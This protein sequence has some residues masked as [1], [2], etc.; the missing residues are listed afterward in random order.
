M[1]HILLATD[2]EDTSSN[3]AAFA[4]AIADN[5]KAKLT[6]YHAFGKP[7]LQMGD[8]SDMMR[9]DKVEA[10]MRSLISDVRS[11]GITDVVVNYAADIDYPGDG[12]LNQ[13]EEGDFDLL[14]IGLREPQEGASQFSSLAFKLLR[15]ADTAVL[16][17]PPMATFHGIQEIVFATDLDHADE[18]VLEQLQSWRQNMGADLFVVNV[19]DDEQGADEARKVLGKW[20][21]RYAS[22]ARMH[23]ELMEGDFEN[24]IGAYVSQ[25]GGDML[26][27]QSHTRGFFARLFT[28]SSA[29]DI[30]HVVEVPLLVMRGEE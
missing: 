26:V 19:Y 18:V 13:L 27:L 12:I 30:A 4:L 11:P 14:V 10:R 15:E 16:A 20:R 28:H 21:D 2:L 29:A 23:F 7:S 9:Q 3:V 1:Q 22:R 25:R 5:F 8:T 24:D 6:V 17:I